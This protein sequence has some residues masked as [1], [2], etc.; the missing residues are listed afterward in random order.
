MFITELEYQ[1][2]GSGC[3]R[4]CDPNLKPDNCLL[5]PTEGCFCPEHHVFHNGSCVPEKNCLIC[6]EEGHVNGDVWNPD[7]C[8]SCS[9][10]NKTVTCQKTDCPALD[11][12]CEDQYTP[13]SVPGSEEH[14]CPK[15]F[16]G[17]LEYNDLTVL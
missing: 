9:C 14:C 3:K 11:A 5:A 13:V 1:A 15:Y 8:T 10:A 2:C 16:C 6:D 12:V 7:K 4:T 17:T